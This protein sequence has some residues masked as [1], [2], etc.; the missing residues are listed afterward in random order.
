MSLRRWLPPVLWAA[1]LLVCTSLPGRY[2]P[3]FVPFPHADKL[4]HL[5]LYGVLGLLTGRALFRTDRLGQWPLF[6]VL[7]FMLFGALDEWHQQFIPG[8]S[9][10]FGDWLA[11]STGVLVGIAAAMKLARPERIS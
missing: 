9:M 11:D 5:T 10:E 3:T 1:F 2:L 6:L 4:V 7:F 8:R